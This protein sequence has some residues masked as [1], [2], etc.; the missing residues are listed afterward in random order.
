MSYS[1]SKFNYFL[2]FKKIDGEPKMNDIPCSANNHFICEFDDSINHN[3][4]LNKIDPSRFL[5]PLTNY[6]KYEV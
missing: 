2:G 3:Q 1:T 4:K 5:K 6:S